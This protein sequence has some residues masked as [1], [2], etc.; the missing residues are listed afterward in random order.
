MGE[1]GEEEIGERVEGLTDCQFVSLPPVISHFLPDKP[2]KLIFAQIHFCR[3]CLFLSVGI[4]LSPP[5]MT[6][7]P[8]DKPE[9]LLG[10]FHIQGDTFV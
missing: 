4:S 2:E 8:S 7:F 5:T 9:K 3:F 10:G 6:P 1:G